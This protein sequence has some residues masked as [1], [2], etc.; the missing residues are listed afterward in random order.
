MENILE[1]KYLL[2]T[3]FNEIEPHES[4]PPTSTAQPGGYINTYNI[5]LYRPLIF[6][7]LRSVRKGYSSSS[8]CVGVS[9]TTLTV[10]YLVYMPKIKVPLG[11]LWYFIIIL[12]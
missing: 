4:Y 9:V 12:Y 5:D 2:F 6:A 8:T 1:T 10:T 7:N 11:F 3:V